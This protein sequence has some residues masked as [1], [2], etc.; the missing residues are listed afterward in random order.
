MANTKIDMHNITSSDEIYSIIKTSAETL[1]NHPEMAFAIPAIMLRGAPGV[2]KSTIVKSVAEE[3]GIGFVDV[4]L[5]QMERVD[6]AGLPS[7]KNGMT[8]WNV[9]SFWPRNEASKGIILLDEIT[10]AP[11]DCQVAAYSVVLDRRIPNSNY[12]LPDG[13]LIVAAGNRSQDHAVVKAMSSAL[14]NRFVHFEVDANAKD[15][16]NWAIAN[17]INPSVTGFIQYLPDRL[18]KMDGQN[19]EQ[20]WPSPRSWERV[21]NM[22]N[23][24]QNNEDVLRKV[25]YGLIGNSVGLEFMEFWKMQKEFDNIYDLMIDEKREI[26]LPERADQKCAV[27]SAVIYHL[28]NGKDE[29]ETN[30]LVDGF[31]RFIDKLESGYGSMMVN[32]AFQGNKRVSKM[33]AMKKLMF[34]KKYPEVAKKFKTTFTDTN[35]AFGK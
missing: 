32:A 12:K 34:H 11:S 5:A 21:S 22:M 16:N 24:Y 9:P 10:S 13:W 29:K 17:S 2:G 4:R 27:A 26:K 7:V 3:L 23:L 19:L 35:F 30:K 28:W 15:W 6:F 33:E 14:A 20:G 31:F 25:V 18:F 1:I 8:E